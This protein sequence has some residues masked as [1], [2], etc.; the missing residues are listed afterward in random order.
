VRL[1]FLSSSFAGV[2]LEIYDGGHRVA[3]IQQYADAGRNVIRWRASQA[4]H[5]AYRVILKAVGLDGQRALDQSS[6]ALRASIQRSG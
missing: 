3:R 5:G 1:P 2:V 4:L 6:L